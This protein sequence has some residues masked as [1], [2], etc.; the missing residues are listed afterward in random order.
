MKRIVAFGGG[1]IAAR[2]AEGGVHR[3]R[4]RLLQARRPADG[5]LEV[6]VG[7]VVIEGLVRCIEP[8]DDLE[9]FGRLVVALLD[10]RR[11]EHAELLRVPAAD[12]VEP[13]AA[14][15]D[16]IDRRQRL[17]RIERMHQRHMHGHE[18]A[19]PLGRGG[20]ARR[21]GEGLERP[22][23][24]LVLAAETVPARD[25]QEE[26]QPGAV[27]D[28]RGGEIVLPAG[29]PAL[30]HVGDGQPAIGIGRE[31]AELQP[32]RAF[33]RMRFR[34]AGPPDRCGTLRRRQNISSLK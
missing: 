8:L 6:V 25:R 34:H 4:P 7:A 14:L 29:L 11:A 18:Q 5:L 3:H 26:F 23:A 28:L 24:H 31:D 20:E 30:R 9:P 16:V 15:A 22:F 27:G 19:D 10:Q 12:D 1:E 17:G 21:P 2:S 13:G 33:E 32:V